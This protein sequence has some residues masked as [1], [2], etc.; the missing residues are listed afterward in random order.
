M[1]FGFHE[2]MITA[3]MVGGELLMYD[4]KLLT[5]DEE[6]ISRRASEIAPM[7]WARYNQEMNMQG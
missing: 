5:L 3:T 2:S 6:E 1:L 7:V 4:R